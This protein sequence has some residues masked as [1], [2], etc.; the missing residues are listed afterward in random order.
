MSNVRA[1]SASQLSFRVTRFIHRR[2]NPVSGALLPVAPCSVLRASMR[3]HTVAQQQRTWSLWE[4]CSRRPTHA[5]GTVLFQSV[6][7]RFAP[8]CCAGQSGN[9]G[10]RS[11]ASATLK[12]FRTR[13]GCARAGM[14]RFGYARHLA[15]QHWPAVKAIHKVVNEVSSKRFPAGALTL[16]SSGHP[17]AG[18]TVTLR[19]GR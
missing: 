15:E 17:T 14:H 16:P 3:K 4:S 8:P 19:Q 7:W 11:S 9:C 13:T 5:P 18:H 6:V 12:C 10:C 2:F 1:L